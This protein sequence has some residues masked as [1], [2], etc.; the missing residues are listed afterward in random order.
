MGRLC[1]IHTFMLEQPRS[2][3]L[4]CFNLEQT[5]VYQLHY[6]NL[7]SQPGSQ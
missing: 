2:H 7:G 3:Q 5:R 4:H 6:F 1:I